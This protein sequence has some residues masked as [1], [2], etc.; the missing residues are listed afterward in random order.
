MA[1]GPICLETSVKVEGL[2]HPLWGWDEFFVRVLAEM[3]AVP[4]KFLAGVAEL[5]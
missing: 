2:D 4:P 5:P 1:N 3:F